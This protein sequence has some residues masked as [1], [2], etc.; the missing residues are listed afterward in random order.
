MPRKEDARHL[1]GRGTF[2]SDMILPGQSEVA[3]L[4][5]PVA[6]ARIARVEKAR[7]AGGAQS[8]SARTCPRRRRSSRLRPCRPTS[9]PSS[10]RSPTARCAS[11]AKRSPC[12]V[13]PTRAEAEDLAEQIEVDFEELPVLVDAHDARR[14]PSIRI[15]EEWD[16][17]LFLTLQLES[18]F[19]AEAKNAPTSWSGARSSCHAS[20]WCRWKARRSSPTGTTGPTSSWSTPRRRCRTSSASASRSFLGLPRRRCG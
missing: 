12:C 9:S 15:H 18:G 8:S 13:A 14:D 10:T 17:N 1:H 16:D 3:F 7:G 19:D 2:V 20:R 4:R 5:S 11:S 6:H